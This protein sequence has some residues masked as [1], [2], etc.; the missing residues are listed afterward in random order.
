[1][2]THSFQYDRPKGETIETLYW[3]SHCCSVTLYYAPPAVLPLR[4]IRIPPNI[5]FE[6]PLWLL[7]V[8]QRYAL[9]RMYRGTL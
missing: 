9:Y 6:A 3:M 5:S 4:M 7:S 2:W 1:M 8:H